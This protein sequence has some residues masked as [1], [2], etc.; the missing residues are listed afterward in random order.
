M[1]WPNA[2]LALRERKPQGDKLLGDIGGVQPTATIVLQICTSPMERKL[3][4]LR[5]PSKPE[6]TSQPQEQSMEWE[7]IEAK[8]HDMTLRLRQGQPPRVTPDAVLRPIPKATQEP[9][10]R[11][12]DETAARA[13]V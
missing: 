6:I 11:P 7:R 3:S 1:L 9:D 8:W 12:G 2:I 5:F 13:T 10:L 4:L